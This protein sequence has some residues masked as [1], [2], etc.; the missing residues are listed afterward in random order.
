[1]RASIVLILIATPLMASA[2]EP[3]A[4]PCLARADASAFQQIGFQMQD[5]GAYFEKADPGSELALRRAA[6]MYERIIED[7]KN[8]RDMT[9]NASLRRLYTRLLST[10]ANQKDLMMV[11]ATLIKAQD[12]RDLNL[13][14]GLVESVVD[15]DA[16]R[17]AGPVFSA[18]ELEKRINDFG[19]MVMADARTFDRDW[20][21]WM[22]E[23]KEGL[24]GMDFCPTP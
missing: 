20:Q 17:L 7:V 11:G 23:L 4:K 6:S 15:E 16:K 1:M 24:K 21:S 2:A 5:V 10:L 13:L 12:E 18:I 8:T 14:K 19:E 22:N 3:G 9:A